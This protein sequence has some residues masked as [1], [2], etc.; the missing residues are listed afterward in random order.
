M[1]QFLKAATKKTSQD[2]QEFPPEY[3]EEQLHCARDH[4]L[5][6]TAQR[7][8]GASPAGDI[9]ELSGHNPVPCALDGPAGAGRLS[10][11]RSL[12]RVQK[13]RVRDS[14]EVL[15]RRCTFC[16]AEPA[17]SP[18]PALEETPQLAAVCTATGWDKLLAF[19]AILHNPQVRQQHFVEM[20]LK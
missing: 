13:P 4:T 9:P 6:Q 7:Q 8:R 17:A 2:A 16:Q 12:E 10:V 20:Q 14:D 5:E 1:V 15:K 18:A 3:E 19:A 11:R